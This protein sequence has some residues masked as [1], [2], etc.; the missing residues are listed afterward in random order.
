MATLEEYRA[1][2]QKLRQR[3]FGPPTGAKSPTQ[4]LAPD[5]GRISDEVLFGQIW[6]EL[7]DEV[8]AARQESE[9]AR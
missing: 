4:E 7:R 8:Y 1:I 5:L 3:V 2:G 6:S 9:R